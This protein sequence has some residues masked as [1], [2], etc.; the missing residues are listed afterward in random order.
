VEQPGC[1][2]FQ[3]DS[4]SFTEYIVFSVS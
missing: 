2:A 3:V 1:W 4:A